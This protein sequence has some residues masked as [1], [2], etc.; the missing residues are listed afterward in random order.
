MEEECLLDISVGISIRASVLENLPEVSF[1]NLLMYCIHSSTVPT[2][3][4]LLNEN[5]PQKLK[6]LNTKL[7]VTL[8]CRNRSHMYVYSKFI[9][10]AMTKIYIFVLLQFKYFN[11]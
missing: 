2:S 8:S 11:V 3:S 7:K 6:C 10:V 1:L 5:D 9:L 4:G